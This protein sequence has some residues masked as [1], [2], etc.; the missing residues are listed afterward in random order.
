M[1]SH[2]CY[3]IGIILSHTVLLI[4]VYACNNNFTLQVC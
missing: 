1:I 2:N 3:D 4:I